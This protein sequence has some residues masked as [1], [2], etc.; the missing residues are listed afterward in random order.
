MVSSEM[1]TGVSLCPLCYY[2]SQA[3]SG[4]TMLIPWARLQW[5]SRPCPPPSSRPGPTYRFLCSL[6]SKPQDAASRSQGPVRQERS[7]NRHDGSARPVL[8]LSESQEVN[9]GH[10]RHLFI[11][12]QLPNILRG[13]I[14]TAVL[15]GSSPQ[16]LSE[17]I[18]A[19]VNLDTKQIRLRS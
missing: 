18:W 13:V 11:G 4:G 3:Q 5:Y 12:V 15:V 2:M 16:D 7:V 8:H 19:K 14:H 1:V 17:S 9:P 10:Y 6:L